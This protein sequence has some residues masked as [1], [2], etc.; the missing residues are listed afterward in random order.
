MQAASRLLMCRKNPPTKAGSLAATAL[1]LTSSKGTVAVVT[2][3][4]PRLDQQWPFIKQQKEQRLSTVHAYLAAAACRQC[5]R[6]V[7]F[8]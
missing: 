4:L 5:R 7:P 6:S 2:S 3:N 1:A 8:E